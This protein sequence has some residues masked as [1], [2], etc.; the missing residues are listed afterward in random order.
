MV[1]KMDKQKIL[2]KILKEHGSIRAYLLSLGSFKPRAE[3]MRKA[4]EECISMRRL[5]DKARKHN[6]L[7]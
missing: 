3:R 2:R 5:R 1:Y 7:F 6:L 4:K